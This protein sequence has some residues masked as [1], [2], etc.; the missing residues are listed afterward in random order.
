MNF[1][2]QWNKLQVLRHGHAIEHVLK[3]TCVMI[4]EHASQETSLA[5]HLRRM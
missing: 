5:G 1:Q 4:M 3:L 2:A